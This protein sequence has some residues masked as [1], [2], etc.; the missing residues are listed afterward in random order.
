MASLQDRIV[1]AMRLQVSTFEEVE[2]D[3]TA[4][5]QAAMV[6]ALVG[7][8]SAI[9][10]IRWIGITGFVGGVVSQLVGWLIASGI[11]LLVGTRLFP[12]R[13][14]Q[15]DYGQMLRTLGFAQAPGLFNVLAFIPILGWLVRL[16]VWIWMLVAM[17]IAV[18]QALDYEDTLRAVIV[19]L[20]AWI[21]MVV[22]TVIF[23]MMF[24]LFGLGA[25]M[26]GG[27]L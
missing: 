13:N 15:A 7:V 27:M 11:L 9:A 22:V 26:M 20:V 23:G 12:G 19:V 6:V 10:S 18:R 3:A 25:G 21:V 17:V 16:V 4:T 8:A 1:G 2:H 5:S 14:T 24:G